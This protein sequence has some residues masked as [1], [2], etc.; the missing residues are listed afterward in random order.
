MYFSSLNARTMTETF[1]L[2]MHQVPISRRGDRTEFPAPLGHEAGNAL[3]ASPIHFLKM[4]QLLRFL[5]IGLDI[6]MRGLL[7]SIS[8]HPGNIDISGP[9]Q[10]GY[11]ASH[12]PDRCAF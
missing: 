1:G 4:H 12:R 11:R 5:V 6:M 3:E 7:L 2:G 9:H 8:I 10:V